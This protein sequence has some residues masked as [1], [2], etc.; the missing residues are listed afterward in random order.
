MNERS[1]RVSM[2]FLFMLAQV[3]TSSL[4]RNVIYALGFIIESLGFIIESLGFIIEFL[5]FIIESLGFIIESLGF[6]IESLEG[7]S[8]H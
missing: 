7:L 6:I 5:W 2:T 4:Q 3:K 1:R 8:F